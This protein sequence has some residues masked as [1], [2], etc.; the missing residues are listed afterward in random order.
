[1]KTMSL[2]ASLSFTCII[3]LICV[4][5]SV[6]NSYE[7]PNTTDKLA[8]PEHCTHTYIKK[9]IVNNINMDNIANFR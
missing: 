6:S 7:L 9:L 4:I 3:S 5:Y 2:F 1:M 8:P